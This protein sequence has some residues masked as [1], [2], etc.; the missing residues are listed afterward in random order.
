[1][2]LVLPVR[3]VPQEKLVP[4]DPKVLLVKLVLPVRRVLLE[5]LVP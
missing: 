5:N 3:K 4:L 1:M 2:K